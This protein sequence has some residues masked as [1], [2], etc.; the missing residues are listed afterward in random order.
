MQRCCCCVFWF[1]MCGY[2][3]V[4]WSGAGLENTDC[5]LRCSVCPVSACFG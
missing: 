2:G 5:L 4:L 1:W 3:V